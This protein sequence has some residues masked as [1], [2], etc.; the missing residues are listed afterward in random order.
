VA[1]VNDGY[2]TYYAER[3]WQLLPAIYRTADTDSLDA[4]GPLREL[5]NRIGAQVAVVRR[6]IDRLWADQSIETCDDWVIPYIGDLLGTNLVTGSHDPRAQRLDVAK[7]IHYRRRKGT[8]EVLEELAYDVTGWTAHVV[9]GFRRLARTRHGLDP[10]VGPAAF[11]A[12]SASDVSQLLQ[13]EGL[14]GLLTGGLA[15]GF[16]DLRSS[17]GAALTGTAFDESFHMPDLRAGRGAV[18]HFG[19]PKLLVFLWRLTSFPVVN[20][21][22]VAVANCPNQYVFDPTGREIPLFLP[23]PPPPDYSGSWSPAHEWQV[24]GPLTSSLETAITDTGAD[25]PPPLR[26]PYPDAT[27]SP[28]YSVG[29]GTQLGTIWP[30]IGRFTTAATPTETPTVTYQ[31]GF[32]STVGAGPY[33]RDLLGDPPAVVGAETVVTGGSGLDTALT[34]AGTTGTV[35]IGAIGASG[36]P[37]SFTYTTLSDVGSTAEPIASLLVRAGQGMRPVLRPASGTPWIFTGGDGAQLVLDGLTVS[38]CDIV[39][40]GAFETVRITACTIDPGTAAAGSPPLATA[41]D[42]T[43]L[44]PGRIFIEAD[45]AAPAGEDGTIAKLLIDHCILGPVRSRFGGSVETLTITDSIVQGLPATSGSTYAPADIFD[46]PL[47]ARGLTV[48]GTPTATQ[49][50]TLPAMLMARLQTLSPP[51]VPALTTYAAQSL[52]DQESGLPSA[53]IDGLNALVGGPS[54]YDPALFATVDL[55]PAVL[56]L[57]AEAAALDAADLA[58]LNRALLDESFPVALGVAALA[59]AD[60]TVQL[61]RVTVLGRI[62]VHRLM[63]SDSIMRDFAAVDDIQEGCVRFSAYAD[64]SVIPRQYESAAIASGAPIF[65]SDTY[66]RPGYAQLL[67]T[68]DSSIVGTAGASISSGAENSSE[69]G[70]FS[71]DLNPAKEQGLLIKYAE[72]MPLGLTPVIV[73]VT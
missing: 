34:G 24:P 15:G 54:L 42:G 47:L 39:L 45:P 62:A 58:V 12:A 37:E 20:G 68:A 35:T 69:M 21:T 36:Q 14:A 51:A 50:A 59:V 61:N 40:R 71:A 16:A 67:E 60:A 13:T 28:R 46:P 5:I 56:G 66:G 55:S 23:P 4:S 52:S 57:A 41:V 27:V 26:P 44:A 19:I 49:P 53:V 33:D 72:Y 9:E 10:A 22:P 3:L 29:G 63:A 38:G 7:T 1:E 48:G 18:G 11:A 6:S 43:V 70:A 65:T 17:H 73:H 8:A 25:P 64:A 30:E 32:S 31:Y 2:E